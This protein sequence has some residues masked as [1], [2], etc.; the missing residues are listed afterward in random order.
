MNSLSVSHPALGVPP[1]RQSSWFPHQGMKKNSLPHAHVCREVDVSVDERHPV[2]KSRW[3]DTEIYLSLRKNIFK[4]TI[5]LLVSVDE[6]VSPKFCT[7]TSM[8]VGYDIAQRS[9]FFP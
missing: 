8:S 6:N 7:K 2:C 4:A 9:S 1:S 5:V 3:L